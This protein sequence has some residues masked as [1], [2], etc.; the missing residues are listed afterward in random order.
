MVP[1]SRAWLA[2]ITIIKLL[3]LRA[4]P[5]PELA[6]TPPMCPLH[7][8]SS[9][10]DFASTYHTFCRVRFSSLEWPLAFDG[11]VRH[12]ASRSPGKFTPV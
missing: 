9:F 6:V 4:L 12:R 10:T 1:C 3:E 7:L 11:D 8:V 5:S 2:L